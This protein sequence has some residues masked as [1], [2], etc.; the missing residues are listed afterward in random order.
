MSKLTKKQQATWDRLNHVPM[1]EANTVS[2]DINSMY[3]SQVMTVFD[4]KHVEPK[5][6]EIVTI[7]VLKSR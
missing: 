2:F 1:P 5:E 7:K 4:I 3:A 6:G